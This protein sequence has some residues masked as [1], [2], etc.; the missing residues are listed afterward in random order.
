MHAIALTIPPHLAIGAL[1]GLHPSPVAI[2][3]EL[4][5]PNIP[6]TVFVDVALM[7]VA[8]DAEAARNGAVGKYRSDVD[9]RTAR[10]VMVAHLAL[11]FT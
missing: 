1:V 4:V 7:I 9:A 6:K 11:V 2:D 8:T 5:L 3:L 10:I